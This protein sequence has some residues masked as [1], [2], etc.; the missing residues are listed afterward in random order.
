MRAY[1]SG[2]EIA[3]PQERP[4][5]QERRPGSGSGKQGGQRG[6][7]RGDEQP[8]FKEPAENQRGDEQPQSN[9]NRRHW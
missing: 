1:V 3:A 5:V 6:K 2:H 4:I 7:Q 8:K 9:E